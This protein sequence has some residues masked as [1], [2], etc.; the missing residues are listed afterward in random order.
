[1][2]SK[3]IGIEEVMARTSLSRSTIWRLWRRGCFPKPVGLSVN[4]KG[5]L[6]SQVGAWIQA[7]VEG[8]EWSDGAAAVRVTNGNE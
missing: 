3:F 7:R 6:D 4:R 8:V 1:M 2:E 5:W